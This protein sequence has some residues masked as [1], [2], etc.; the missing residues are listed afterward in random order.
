M[1]GI[2]KGEKR[3][4]NIN[5]NFRVQ[6]VSTVSREYIQ[7]YKNQVEQIEKDAEVCIA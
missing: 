5:K 2:K 4:K 1:D 7:E 3:E 6:L